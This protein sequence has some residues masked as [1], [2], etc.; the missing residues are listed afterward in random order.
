[1]DLKVGRV[2][3]SEENFIQKPKEQNSLVSAWTYR[4]LSIDE[5]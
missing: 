2:S 5:R 1:M 4:Q 3:H